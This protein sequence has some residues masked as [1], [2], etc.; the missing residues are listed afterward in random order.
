MISQEPFFLTCVNPNV[1]QHRAKSSE[2]FF[3]QGAFCAKQT[4]FSSCQERKFEPMHGQSDG[5]GR[6]GAVPIPAR[7]CTVKV[8][9]LQS[10]ENDSFLHGT[11]LKIFTDCKTS[12]GKFCGEIDKCRRGG[13]R[14]RLFKQRCPGP[15]PGIPAP[16]APG[17][18][19]SARGAASAPCRNGTRPGERA[20]TGSRGT[21]S[22]L[23][24]QPGS[25][26][27][28]RALRPSPN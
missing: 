2:G 6:K 23:R 12:C 14:A 20:H 8:K 21:R 13:L 19:G 17:V 26:W 16:R 27:V 4:K 15:V 10:S 3:S 5:C 1:K 18:A 7:R 11:S 22:A 24:L 25:R 9:S 28:C